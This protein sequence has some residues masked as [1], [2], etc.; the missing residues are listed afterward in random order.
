MIFKVSGK[1]EPAP[2][3]GVLSVVASNY[4]PLGL[5]VFTLI[6]KSLLQDLCRGIRSRRNNRETDGTFRWNKYLS[7]LC[8]KCQET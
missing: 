7:F 1:E 8:L 4:E 5:V 6:K 3:R 2:K